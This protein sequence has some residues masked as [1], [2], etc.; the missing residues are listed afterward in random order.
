MRSNRENISEAIL[1]VELQQKK[2]LM[3]YNG[4]QNDTYIKI[5][6]ALPRLIAAVKRLLEKGDIYPAVGHHDYRAFESNIDFDIRYH[7]NINIC[8]FY[9]I[10][11]L[12]F[13]YIIVIVTNSYAIVYNT[14][15]LFLDLW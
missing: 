8:I 6:V 2:S 14:I 9:V 15:F 3:H 12:R 13:K 1:L 7:S 5:T 4:D 11:N 10:L